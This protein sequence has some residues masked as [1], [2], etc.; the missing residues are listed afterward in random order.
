M[1]LQRPEKNGTLK[2]TGEKASDK[3]L[4]D[5]LRV[6]EG[7]QRGRQVAALLKRDMIGKVSHY[8]SNTS[9]ERNWCGLF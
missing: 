2:S 4:E 9:L 5:T 6:Y 7:T 8:S 1:R 3:K